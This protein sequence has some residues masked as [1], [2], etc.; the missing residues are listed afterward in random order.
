MVWVLLMEGSSKAL[1]AHLLLLVPEY[2]GSHSAS[3]EQ[4]TDRLK[5]VVPEY[6]GAYSASAEQD[7]DRLKPA[8][9][10]PS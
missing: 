9:A 10:Q 7:T 5:L 8:G 6:Q 3:V 2:Q 1:K 4:D